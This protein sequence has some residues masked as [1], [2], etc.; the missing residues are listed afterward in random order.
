MATARKQ[1]KKAAT[2]APEEVTKTSEKVVVSLNSAHSILFELGERK[3]KIN[4]QNENLRGKEEGVLVVGK[5]GET[6]LDKQDWDTIREKYKNMTIFKTGMIFASAD[7]AS[8]RARAKEQGEL[9][10]GLEPVDTTKTQTKA[11]KR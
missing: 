7:T 4:G 1:S 8:A 10:H 3:I 11:D 5:F 2:V 6:V 9:R